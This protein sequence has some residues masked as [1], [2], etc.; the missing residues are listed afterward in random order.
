MN[1]RSLF[2]LMSLVSFSLSIFAMD[3]NT[4]KTEV[5]E[6]CATALKN[7]DYDGPAIYFFCE[8]VFSAMS[9][10]VQAEPSRKGSKPSDILRFVFSNGS[11]AEAVK[12]KFMTADEYFF[13][14]LDP[15]LPELD[16]TF[17][18]KYEEL[19][20]EPA[21]WE[22]LKGYFKEHIIANSFVDLK[23]RLVAEDQ[24]RLELERK[25]IFLRGS[26]VIIDPSRAKEQKKP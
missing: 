1:T 8:G 17:L 19:K 23:K 10:Q 21:T 5:T 22:W 25:G 6:A 11:V 18:E 3:D 16:K 7:I 9:E 12:P 2:L 4:G 20:D 14:I 24:E 13:T 26:T 15:K